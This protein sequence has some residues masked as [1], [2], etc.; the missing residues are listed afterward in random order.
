[1]ILPIAFI[2]II[3]IIII[4]MSLLN[5]PY[6]SLKAETLL[7]QWILQ[8]NGAYSLLHKENIKLSKRKRK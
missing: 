6:L 3:I 2:I 5:H 1:M 4:L 7:F 8:L